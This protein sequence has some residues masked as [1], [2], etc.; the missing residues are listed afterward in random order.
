[1]KTFKKIL[2]DVLAVVLF[3]LISVAYFFPADIEGKILYRHD[4]SA[5]KGLGREMTEHR[6]ETGEVTRWMN[7][8]FSGM[9]RTRRHPNTQ[10]Q[11]A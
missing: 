10:A 8:V 1:M 11:R 6:A 7:S 3:A 2:P 9:R 4:S 5:G